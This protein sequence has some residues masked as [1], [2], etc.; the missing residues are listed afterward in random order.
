MVTLKSKVIF[1]IIDKELL[2]FTDN[3]YVDID[4]ENNPFIIVLV[5]I[6]D[7]IIDKKN[8]N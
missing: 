8:N 5:V 2:S 4:Y 7:N 6:I 1:G 3:Y